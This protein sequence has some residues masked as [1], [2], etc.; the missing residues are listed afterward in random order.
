MIVHNDRD[1]EYQ[2]SRELQNDWG[3][4]A[5]SID[6]GNVVSSVDGR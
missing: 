1:I 4:K 3:T 2:Q 5:F 6:L